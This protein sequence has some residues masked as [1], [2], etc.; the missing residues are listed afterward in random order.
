[1]STEMHS[2][3][4]DQSRSFSHQKQLVL[5]L[6]LASACLV[7]CSHHVDRLLHSS[8]ASAA[9]RALSRPFAGSVLLSKSLKLMETCLPPSL[10]R[11]GDCSVWTTGSP[12]SFLD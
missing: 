1:M 11:G 12:H 8:A 7:R 2:G 5:L 9:P 10:M 4:P 3:L 6:S